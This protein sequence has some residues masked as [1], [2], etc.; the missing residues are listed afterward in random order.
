MNEL[1]LPDAEFEI[2]CSG[3]AVA[4]AIGPRDEAKKE[5]QHYALIYGQDGPT[6]VFE[7]FKTYTRMD[8]TKW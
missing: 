1:I 3:E 8:I 4:G 5:A 6:E 2:R 7:V